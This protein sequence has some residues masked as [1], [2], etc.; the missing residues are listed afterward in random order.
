MAKKKSQTVEIATLCEEPHIVLLKDS[1][2]WMVARKSKAG[3]QEYGF[4][5]HN[6]KGAIQGAHGRIVLAKA[7]P[8]EHLNDLIAVCRQTRRALLEL[9]LPGRI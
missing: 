5:G 9:D 7:K 1:G 2:G 3:Y 6:L 4:Y 8:V